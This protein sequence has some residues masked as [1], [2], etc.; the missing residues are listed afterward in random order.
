MNT[1][2]SQDKA[3]TQL[4]TDVFLLTLFS[5]IYFLLFLGGH[6]LLIPDEG[7][8]PEIAREML[9]S[10]NWTTPTINGVPFLD[11]PIMYYWLEAFSMKLFGVHAFSIRLPMALF[12]ALGVPIMYCFGRK[13]YNRRTGLLAAGI[14]AS[15]PLYFLAGHYA[16]MDLEVAT[17][18]WISA[19]LFILG[20]QHPWKSKQRRWILY[21]AYAVAGGA[22][23]TKGMMGFVFPAMMVGLW[24]ILTNNWRTIRELHLPEGVIIFLIITVP[25]VW[26]VQLQNPDFLYYFFYYQQV[27]RFVGAGFNNALGPWFYFAVV[28]VAI[29]PWSIIM[30]CRLNKGRLLLWKNRHKDPVTLMILLWVVS[31]FIFFSIPASKIVGY[32]LPIIPPLCLLVAKAL[33]SLIK[34]GVTKGFRI[35][36]AIGSFILFCMGVTLLV[37][38]LCQSKIPMGQLYPVFIPMGI[39]MILGAIYTYGNFKLGKLVKAIVTIMVTMAIF[40]VSVLLVVDAFDKKSSAPLIE[41][42]KE[43]IKPDTKIISYE[44]YREDLPL[45]LKRKVYIVYDWHNPDLMNTD[46]WAR[47]FRFGISEYKTVHNNQWPEWYL[48]HADFTVMWKADPSV[49]VFTNEGYYQQ[50]EKTLVPKPKLL[51]TYRGQVVF[52]Q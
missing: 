46:N 10:G 38:P 41:Q 32:I 44:G 39:I 8:Y 34:N 16:N 51:A 26:A 2:H 18:L 4:W 21:L 9:T 28:F 11:K 52:K 45:L 37:F 48:D 20:L 22:A 1:N 35:T 17:F 29:L 13:F 27:D 3:L 43:Y 24:V 25:W 36:F 30:L 7:R 19:F 42:V 50:L 33:D 49:I 40:N 15:A 14:L 5:V 31:I 6:H 47:E 12:G 23:L